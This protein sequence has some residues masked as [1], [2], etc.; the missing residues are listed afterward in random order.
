MIKGKICLK[1]FFYTFL[2]PPIFIVEEL[3]P[4]E[5]NVYLS[6]RQDQSEQSNTTQEKTSENRKIK[7]LEGVKNKKIYF[8]LSV[9]VPGGDI[10]VVVC[11]Y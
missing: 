1:Y 7:T 10:Q 5:E 8:Q 11:P 6:K 4:H 3:Q 9:R 2:F